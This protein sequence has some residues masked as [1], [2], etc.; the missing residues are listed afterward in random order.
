MYKFNDSSQIR[1][2]KKKFARVAGKIFLNAALLLVVIVTIGI[3]YVYFN[4]ET[5]ADGTTEEIV[6]NNEASAIKPSA[7]NPNAPASAAVLGITSP[8]VPGHNTS[9]SV[10]TNP[11]AECDIVFNYKDKNKKEITYRDSGLI[12]KTANEFGSISWAWTVGKEVPEG[13]WPVNV[14]CHYYDRSAVVIADLV[15]SN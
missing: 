15:V 3:A 4:H 7:P 14:T 8:V 11:G 12:R 10:R 13:K 1:I 9:L 6:V 2:L 5:S